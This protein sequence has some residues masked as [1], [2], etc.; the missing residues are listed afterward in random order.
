MMCVGL[1]LGPLGFIFVWYLT[2]GKWG[3]STR[4]I[5]EAATRNIYYCAALFL[6][7]LL[8]YRHIYPWAHTENLTSAHL[9]YLSHHWLNL[10][11]FATRGII[12]FVLW[13]ALIYFVNKY[14]AMQDR[15]H[16]YLGRKLSTLGSIGVLVY[17]FAMSFATFDWVMSLLPAWPS[18]I[19]GLIFVAGQG[20]L[21]L[22]L[23]LVVMSVLVKY[24]PMNV[25]MDDVV[26]HDNGKLLLAFVMLWAYFSFSQWLIIWAGN[27][28][29]EIVFFLGRLRGGWQ[30]A[31]LFLILFHFC[32]PFMML[33]SA[34]LKKR[35]A[36]IAFVSAWMIVMRWWDLYWNIEPMYSPSHFRFSWMDLVIPV[37][38]VGIW[39]ALFLRNLMSRPLVPIYE[40]HLRKLVEVEHE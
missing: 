38:L 7:I 40:P 19:Y 21:G 24:E 25:L 31:S 1:T 15:P 17:V 39:S 14:S 4:R 27:L 37:A 11:L 33:L 13:I 29:E 32:V 34:T 35:P 20:I 10:G 12:Y 36:Q 26:F 9:Q 6:V 22:A 8:G 2:N 16:A 3:L 23:T 5:W 18:T 28:P 30:F